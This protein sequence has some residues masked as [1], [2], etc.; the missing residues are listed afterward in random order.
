[1]FCPMCGKEIADD[2]KFCEFCGAA[3]EMDE[4]VSVRKIEPPKQPKEIIP[5]TQPVE[6]TP[7][8]RQAGAGTQIPQGNQ[9]AATP[10]KKSAF[11][12]VIIIICILVALPLLW[13]LVWSVVY[14][15]GYGDEIKTTD[16]TSIENGEGK[17]KNSSDGVENGE[18]ETGNS[19][20]SADIS[21]NTGVKY[22]DALPIEKDFDWY[23]ANNKIDGKSILPKDGN[24]EWIF[25]MKELDGKWEMLEDYHLPSVDDQG[26]T[27]TYEVYSEITLNT[28]SDESVKMTKHIVGVRQVDGTL[29][30]RETASDPE[31]EGAREGDDDEPDRI[32]IVLTDVYG[33]EMYLDEI[34]TCNGHK[35]ITGFL[36]DKYNPDTSILVAMYQ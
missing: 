33:S 25:G 31:Y 10:K 35:Y 9:G 7:Q 28:F 8:T 14:R 34:F 11:K 32:W 17:A 24:G 30:T 19:S 12:I 27:E 26:E 6:I 29:D 36:V 5:P 15:I 16:I 2:S 20:E 4:A 13:R 21:K 22:D 3:Q 18:K 23:W 1:M